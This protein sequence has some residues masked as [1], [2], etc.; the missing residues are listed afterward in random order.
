VTASDEGQL[1]LSDIVLL[2]RA[3]PVTAADEGSTNPFHVGNVI[4]IPN[5]GEPIHRSSKE[6]PFFFKIYLSADSGAPAKLTIELRQQG[7]TLAQMPAEL[8][9][10]D[11]LRRIEYLAGLP[12]EKIPAGDYELKIIVSD[13]TTSVTRSR[14]FTV[15]D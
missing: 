7:H 2:N 13:G 3:E 15:A 8:P 11:A 10:P 5:L 9:K 12:L 14:Q 6:V 1:R 4:A